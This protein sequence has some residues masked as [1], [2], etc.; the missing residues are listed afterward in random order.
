MQVKLLA[1][2][3]NTLAIQM[4]DILIVVQQVLIVKMLAKELQLATNQLHVI[5]QMVILIVVQLVKNVTRQQ[6]LMEK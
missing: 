1:T 4:M 2:H 5:Q 6:A 3:V